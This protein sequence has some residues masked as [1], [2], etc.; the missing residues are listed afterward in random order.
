MDPEHGWEADQRFVREELL[1]EGVVLS[2]FREEQGPFDPVTGR[3]AQGTT[4]SLSRRFTAPA[5]MRMSAPGGSLA[6]AWRGQGLIMTGDEILLVAP[7]DY[8]PALEDRV[9]IGSERWTVK[10]VTTVRPG[11]EPLMH[12]LLIRRV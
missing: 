6:Q 1:E 7:G 5:L 4:P 12:Y 10:A 11:L 8:E 3:R 2:F 9:A